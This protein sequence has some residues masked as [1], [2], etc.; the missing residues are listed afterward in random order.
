MST[1]QEKQPPRATAYDHILL[2]LNRTDVDPKDEQFPIRTIRLTQDNPKLSVGRSSK[3]VSKGLFSAADNGLFDSLVVS[4]NHAEIDA[5]LD[6]G[7]LRITDQGS[8]HGTFVN[9]K[10]LPKGEASVLKSGDTVRFGVHISRGLEVF[11]P[12]TVEVDAVPHVAACIVEQARSYRAPESVDDFSDGGSEC[13]CNSVQN[14]SNTESSDGGRVD[15][16][17]MSSAQSFAL[18]SPVSLPAD[19]TRSL[20]PEGSDDV[21][22]EDESEQ[23]GDDAVYESP[24]DEDMDPSQPYPLEEDDDVKIGGEARPVPEN[25]GAES[26]NRDLDGN[27]EIVEDEDDGGDFLHAELDRYQKLPGDPQVSSSIQERNA[28]TSAT[29]ILSIH[30]LCSPSSALAEDVSGAASLSQ[31]YGYVNETFAD[32]VVA[33]DIPTPAHTGPAAAAESVTFTSQTAVQA[34]VAVMTTEPAVTEKASTNNVE[35][36]VPLAPVSHAAAPVPSPLIEKVESFLAAASQPPSHDGNDDGNNGR[37]ALR[38]MTSN[39]AKKSLPNRKR[40]ADM[41]T[42]D[43]DDAPVPKV[44]SDAGPG[45]G[46]NIG[47]DVVSAATPSVV[48]FKAFN[49]AMA[50]RNTTAT[51]FAPDATAA[52]RRAAPVDVAAKTASPAMRAPAVKRQA[53]EE[54]VEADKK[55][56]GTAWAVAEKVGIAAL[57]GAVVLGSLIYT[58]PTF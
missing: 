27:P 57:G 11:S 51:Q 37:D 5:D 17:S 21:Y 15:N 10:S 8:F 34:P 20:G 13:D 45:V 18:K 58:A 54:A 31:E 9:D 49:K 1:E 16:D 46:P 38:A 52:E 36:T 41:I 30:E 33:R 42:P 12:A 19:D 56:K 43:N 25:D 40:K 50:D 47:G 3:T 26:E 14:H 24:D 4:R 44:A 22:G 55:S 23:E 35:P 39:A 7:V 32:D 53:T 2:S 6:E 48:P 29:S 28:T